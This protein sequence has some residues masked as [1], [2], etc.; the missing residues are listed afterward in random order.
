MCSALPTDL[1]NLVLSHTQS[2]DEMWIEHHGKKLINMLIK[3]RLEIAM[4]PFYFNDQAYKICARVVVNIEDG[5][6]SVAIAVWLCI[7]NDEIP[8][9]GRV[10]MQSDITLQDADGYLFDSLRPS[11]KKIYDYLTTLQECTSCTVVTANLSGHC[12]GCM[13][14]Y[15]TNRQCNGCGA[16]F[17]ELIDGFHEK[18]S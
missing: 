3:D 11:F 5:N 6:Q 15:Y 17:G 13:Q 2:A 8:E 9:D 14:F 10:R 1:E 18:C 12:D 4:I 7:E 16:H